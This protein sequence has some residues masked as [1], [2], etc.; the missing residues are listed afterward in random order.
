MSEANNYTYYDEFQ[1]LTLIATFLQLIK[2]RSF[3]AENINQAS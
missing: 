1:S 2:L 3:Y